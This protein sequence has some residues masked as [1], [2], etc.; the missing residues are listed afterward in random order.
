[1]DETA[2]KILEIVVCV[3]VNET[4]KLKRCGFKEK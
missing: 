1:M 4:K 2:S 3:R